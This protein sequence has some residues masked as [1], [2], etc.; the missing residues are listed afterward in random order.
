MLAIVGQEATTPPRW[1][2]GEDLGVE[3]NTVRGIEGVF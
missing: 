1:L 2:A 3:E